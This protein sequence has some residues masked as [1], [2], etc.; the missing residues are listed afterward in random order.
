M[1][2]YYSAISVVNKSTCDKMLTFKTLN[3][4]NLNN[5]TSCRHAWTCRNMSG[6]VQHNITVLHEI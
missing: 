4:N 6:H 3:N 2:V 1:H 5:E